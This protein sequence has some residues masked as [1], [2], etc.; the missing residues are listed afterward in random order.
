MTTN[1]ENICCSE[2]DKVVE[3]KEEGNSAV[4]CI[5]DPEGFHSVS[6]HLGAVNSLLQLPAVLWCG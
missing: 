3:K 4:S 1:H 2:V 6:G 5:I